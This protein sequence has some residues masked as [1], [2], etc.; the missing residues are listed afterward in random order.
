MKTKC[1]RKGC[2]CSAGSIDFRPAYIDENGEGQ[3]IGKVSTCH[4]C[5]VL[6]DVDWVAGIDPEDIYDESYFRRW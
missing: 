6:T 2:N 4:N 5:Q 1:E 3:S